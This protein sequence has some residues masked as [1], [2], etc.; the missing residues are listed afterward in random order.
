MAAGL[1]PATQPIE[2][3]KTVNIDADNADPLHQLPPLPRTLPPP[4]P[5]FTACSPPQPPVQHA[6]HSVFL[7]GSIEMGRA[8]NWQRRLTTALQHL[9]LAVLN[10]RRGRWDPAAQPTPADATFRSQVE[11]ELDGLQ[12]ADV[13][14]FFFDAATMSPV[15]MLELGLW[16]RSAKMVVCCPDAFWKAGNV[17]I[18]CERE[19]V[20]CV[21]KFED[22]VEETVKMLRAKG[23]DA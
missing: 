6:A 19:D 18:V 9:P 14:A 12:R 4:H 3:D 20:P 13:I 2:G 1:A 7:A 21:A 5:L 16:A 17:R 23:M 15:T 22:L 11:W 8:I 10:P